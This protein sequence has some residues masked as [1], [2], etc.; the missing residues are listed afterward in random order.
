M[1]ARPITAR[2]PFLTGGIAGVGAWLL[3][4]LFTYVL[5]SGEIRDSPV[6]Q[7]F[8]FLGGSLPTWKVVG[9]VF[10][11]AHLS[12]TVFEGLFAGSQNFVGGQDGFSVVLFVLP[13]LLLVAAGLAVGRA[14]GADHDAAD[15]TL[16]GLAVIPGYFLL[17]VVGVFLFT[18]EGAGPD[19]VTGVLLAGLVYPTVFGVVGA[20]IAAWTYSGRAMSSAQDSKP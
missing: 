19:P 2:I 4:Y 10:F 13:P 15:A 9:W 16:A 17:S 8:E 12:S 11:N 18:V 20:L 14:A 3:G 7:V 1:S 5:T 6:R